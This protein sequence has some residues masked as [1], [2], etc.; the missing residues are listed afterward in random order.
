MEHSETW[1]PG[2]L[3]MLSTG[4]PVKVI[5]TEVCRVGGASSPWHGAWRSEVT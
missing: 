2:A 1:L 3:V 5:F 4:Q